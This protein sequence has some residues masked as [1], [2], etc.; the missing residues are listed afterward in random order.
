MT[1]IGLGSYAAAFLAFGTVTAILFASKSAGPADKWILSASGL[2]AA[3]AAGSGVILLQSGPFLGL[4]LLDSVHLILWTLVML[5]WLK[6]PHG[7]HLSPLR[8]ALIVASVGLAAWAVLAAALRLRTGD[9]VAQAVFGEQGAFIAMLGMGLVGLLAVEQVFRNA[10]IGQRESLR[11]LCFSVGAIFVVDTLI[12]AQ[13]ALVGG[14]ASPFWEARGL[15]N[16]VLAPLIAVAAR[17]TSRVE[18]ELGLSRNLAFYTASLVAVGA[19]LVA[20]ATAAYLLRDLGGEWA[21]LLQI[22]FILSG[23][24]VLA[25]FIFSGD[26]RARAKVLI[27]KHFYKTKYDY[28]QEWL[29]LTE[30]LGRSG[31]LK[32]LAANALEG[33]SGIVGSSAG[34]L[35]LTSDGKRYEWIAAMPA[36]AMPKPGHSDR[37]P[38]VAFL[39]T[40]GWIIDTEQYEREPERY[41]HTIGRPGESLLPAKSLVV[42]LDHRGFLQGFMVLEKPAS[43]TDLN[44]EDHDILKT[45]GRQVAV[46]LAQ[47]LA[48]Q[49]LAATLQFEAFNKLSTFLMHDLKNLIAQQELIVGN[50]K[51]FM[52]R[53]GFVEDAVQSI[54][55]GV[56]RMRA[57]LNRLQNA[58]VPER[59]SR[60]GLDKLLYEVCNEC[61]DRQPQPNLVA[62]P[63]G[64]RIEIDR[65]RLAMAITH[66]I[67]NAQDATPDDGSIEVALEIS[68]AGAA[69]V[70]RD[71]GAGMTR[72]FVRDRL[73]R[74]FDSTKGVE[75]MGIGAYQIRETLRAIG[76]SVE[77][78]SEPGAGTTLRLIL[79]LQEAGV[80]ARSVA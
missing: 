72:E 16:A 63:K 46:V 2:S 50:A 4:I 19:F 41:G 70:I 56:Q 60:V 69:I 30:G 48:Q 29:R 9:D 59:T 52:H 49:Q 12:Y 51:R 53:P 77:V 62:P 21:L 42:P 20:M 40:T 22:A 25:S 68:D 64:A 24:G 10:V 75:G 44:F 13:A 15:A 35:W 36:N 38:M 58:S 26:F 14:L 7:R 32:S 33:V 78:E 76:G 71:N 67:R 27:V 43:V 31:E 11:L 23:L 17:R 65:E 74:P 55:S 54:E 37:D 3:W 80:G 61:S 47:A 18:R 5:A 57:I 73:F 66:A 1:W 28:R 45:A 6:T 8:G 39:A 34:N 79:P